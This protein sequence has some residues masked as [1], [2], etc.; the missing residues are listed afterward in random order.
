[1]AIFFNEN[2]CSEIAVSFWIV[3]EIT[4]MLVVLAVNYLYEGLCEHQHFFL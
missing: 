3:K 4:I 2:R 1:M